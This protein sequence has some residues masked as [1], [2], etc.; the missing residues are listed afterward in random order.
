MEVTILGCGG[1]AGVP[2]I[3]DYWGA[4]DPL[5]PKNR[6]LRSSVLIEARGRRVLIDTSPDLRQQLLTAGVGVLDA[7][8]YTHAHADHLNGIDDLRIVNRNVGGAIPI[9]A[10]AATLAEIERRFGHVLEPDPEGRFFKPCLRPHVAEGPFELGG[11]RVV[12]FVQDHGTVK[13]LGYRLGNFAYSVDVK[14]LDEDALRALEGI[15]TWAVDCYDW[16]PH[17]THSHVEQTLG[18]IARVRPERAILTHM[19]ERLDYTALLA[20]CPEGV[21]PAYDGMRLVVPDD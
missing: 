15:H 9:Y 5:N 3:G 13:T 20:W 16:T 8:L 2:T 6:R 21:E 7:V 1:S 14:A 4:C 17:P 19:P 10:D 11:L 18:W 12:P